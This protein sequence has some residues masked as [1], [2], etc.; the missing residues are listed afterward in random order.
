MRPGFLANIKT[1]K[2]KHLGDAPSPPGIGPHIPGPRKPSAKPPVQP[3]GGLFQRPIAVIGK[4]PNF[5]YDAR[6]LYY[7]TNQIQ[8]LSQ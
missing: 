4:Q 7:R 3:P 8:R 6:S 2:P 5:Y 1:Y